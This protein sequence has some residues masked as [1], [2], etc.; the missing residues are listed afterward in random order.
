M[1]QEE[2]RE[3]TLRTLLDTVKE[4]VKE[5][6]CHSVTMKDIMD[7]SNLSKGAIFHYVKSKDELFVRVLRE[8]L[9]ETDRGFRSEVDADAPSFADP[10]R[11]IADSISVYENPE[12]PTNKILLYLLGKEDQPMI[13]E[14]LKAYY[15]RS[16]DLSR[17][18][19][20]TG[21]RHGVISSEVDP[22][23][24]ADLFV[25][26]TTGLRVRASIP[27]APRRFDARTFAEWIS[28]LLQPRKER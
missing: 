5:K 27:G 23:R 21:Q 12:D 24:T 14:A 6:G 15:E 25:L 3:Q 26:L 1:K 20:E 10:M 28:D 11:K 8:R 2:R 22:A 9:E 19:I 13:A 17:Q 4:L 7:R 16:V 18:W